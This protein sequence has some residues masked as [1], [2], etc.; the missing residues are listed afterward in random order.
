MRVLLNTL[1]TL[2]SKTGV[3]H[4]CHRLAEA[5]SQRLNPGELTTFPGSVWRCLMRKPSSSQPI[6]GNSGARRLMSSTAK[7]LGRGAINSWFLARQSLSQFDLYH[8]PNFLPLPSRLPLV[9][10]VHD[11]SVLLHPEWHPTDRVA[12]HERSFARAI[13]NAAR[14]ITVSESVRE[15]LLALLPV[16]ADRVHAIPNGVGPEFFAQP[17]I[18]PVRQRLK[19]PNRYLVYVGTIE[20]RKNLLL[21]L[22]AW[23]GL[24]SPTRE[25]CPL[26]LAGNWGWKANEVA[27]F[28][29]S[30]ARHCNVRHVGY[31]ADGDRPALMAGAAALVFP[32]HYEGFGLPPLE[33]LATGGA[34]LASTAAAHREVL[35]AHAQFID[36]NDLA[37]WRDAMRLAATDDDWLTQIRLE[38]RKHAAKFTWDRT[39]AMTMN[40][41]NQMIHR[42]LAA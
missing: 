35:G 23:C 42:R 3:G 27:Q 39:A 34:V 41:Y 28:Y 26:I 37:G 2:K 19:L 16:S 7:S 4:Y 36:A 21:L 5:L 32:S 14:I 20:P 6:H 25:Q 40:V 31:I 18:E 12:R 33:M 1:A 10:T 24:P 15:E 38:G 11:L 29:E 30:T 8:E 9:I 13:A 17:V 22:K